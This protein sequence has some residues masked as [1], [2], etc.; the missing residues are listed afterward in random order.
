MELIA[1]LWGAMWW[2]P[3]DI[4]LNQN[5]V[6]IIVSDSIACCYIYECFECSNAIIC[7]S[8]LLYT[9]F[10]TTLNTIK[11]FIKISDLQYISCNVLQLAKHLTCGFM[12][13]IVL[14]TGYGAG[15]ECNDV[16]GITGGHCLL[17]IQVHASRV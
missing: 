13:S 2:T 5:P 8:P 17:C 14:M 1:H 7:V 10:L 12:R 16:I 3:K 11:F 15:I 4:P 9:T 6:Y